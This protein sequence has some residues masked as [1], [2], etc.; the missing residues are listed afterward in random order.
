[1]QSDYS[2][3]SGCRVPAKSLTWS[4]PIS[5]GKFRKAEHPETRSVVGATEVRDRPSA[6]AARPQRKLAQETGSSWSGCREA[7]VSS[8]WGNHSITIT[9]Y[10]QRWGGGAVSSD[11]LC[12]LQE[13]TPFLPKQDLHKQCST[14]V[15]RALLGP[16]H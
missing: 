4:L 13:S 16:P 12:Q 11:R 8:D 3:R 10:L 1:M 5:T 7:A 15:L 6:T 14:D 9:A 2:L